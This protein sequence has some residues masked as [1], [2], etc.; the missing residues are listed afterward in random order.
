MIQ[1]FLTFDSMDREPSIRW[2]AV[3]QQ[4]TAV[5]FV[6]QI[7]LESFECKYL[8]LSYERAR[9]GLLMMAHSFNN[10]IGV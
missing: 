10:R 7:Y 8:A 4:F 1:S 2:K 6:F 3:E 9:E 5:L